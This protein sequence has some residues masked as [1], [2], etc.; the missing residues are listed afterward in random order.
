MMSKWQ[1]LEQPV[2]K[3][4]HNGDS[5]VLVLSIDIVSTSK[6]KMRVE[7]PAISLQ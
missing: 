6:N 2:I 4:S 7:Y 5:L 1:V 3:F